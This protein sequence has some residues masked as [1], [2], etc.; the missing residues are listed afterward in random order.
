MALGAKVLRVKISFS[1]VALTYLSQ[2]CRMQ[3][4]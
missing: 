1:N 4:L 2:K 3:I